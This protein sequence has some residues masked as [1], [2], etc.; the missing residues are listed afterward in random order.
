MHS[1]VFKSLKDV[2]HFYNTHDVEG[3]GWAKPEG[4]RNQNTAE[5]SNLGLSR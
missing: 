2:V 5:M 3:S 1:G 4:P